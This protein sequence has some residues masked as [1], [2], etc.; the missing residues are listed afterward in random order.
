MIE[1]VAVFRESNGIEGFVLFTQK[2]K[3]VKISVN[4]S[5]LKT[6]FSH[7]FHIHETGDLRRGCDS[8]CKH[9]N[10]D[11]TN[12]GDLNDENSH[13]GDLGNIVTNSK[14][15]SI[16]EL[17]TDKFYVEEIIGRSVV[18][19]RDTDDLGKGSNKDS[20]VTGNSGKRI[21]CAVIGFSEKSDC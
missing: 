13:A 6:D 2:G 5:G 3:F 10:P 1:G 7:G 17:K 18:I 20:L 15:I 14:G 11:D 9:Y 21:A 19:H 4:I 16:M 8:C 12:H